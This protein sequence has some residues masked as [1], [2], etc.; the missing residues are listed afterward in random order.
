MGHGHIK[1][2]IPLRLFGVVPIFELVVWTYL[3]S[4]FY[5]LFYE[6][7]LDQ[8]ITKKIWK[9]RMKYL[10]LMLLTLF[11]IFTLVIYKFQAPVIPYFYL[12]FGIIFILLPVLFEIFAYPKVFSRF[13]AAAAYFFYFSL[14]YEVTALKLNW[15]T[16]PGEEF[17]GWV[18][19]FGVSFPFEELFFWMVL[20]AFAVLSMYEWYCDNE[21]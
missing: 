4:L 18:S 11:L 3:M 2:V 7:F 10:T 6:S 20:T 17:I 1:R 8:H 9:P 21:K 16:F 12:I 13:A 19:L 5:L 15:W 14:I